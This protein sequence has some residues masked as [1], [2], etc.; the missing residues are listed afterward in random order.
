[1]GAKTINLFFGD[2]LDNDR[3]SRI[4]VSFFDIAKS[5]SQPYGK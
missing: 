1:M 5:E 3:D 4:I 2:D